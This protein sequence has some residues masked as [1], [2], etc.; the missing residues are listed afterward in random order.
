MTRREVIFLTVL[1]VGIASVWIW[2][3]DSTERSA[4]MAAT[5]A[6]ASAAYYPDDA[7][8]YAWLS[9]TP[10]G[11]QPEYM[12]ELVD[13]FYQFEGIREWVTH[14]ETMLAD[15]TGSNFESIGAWMG[16][17]L[18]AAIFDLGDGQP[19]LAVTVEVADQD[20]A[21]EFLAR[22]IERREEKTSE[23][24]ERFVV[25]DDVI[26]LG[27]GDGW[28]E[29]QVY[30]LAGGVMVFATDWGLLREI[31][32]HV[33]GEQRQTL[34]A[35]TK[36]L[37]A[38]S[39]ARDGRFASVYLDYGRMRELVGDGPGVG[40]CSGVPFTP[41]DW[42]MASA[43]WVDSGLIFDVVAPDVT[44]WWTDTSGEATSEVVPAG[45]LGFVSVGFDPDI[46]RWRDVLDGCELGALLPD[47]GFFGLPGPDDGPMLDGDATVAD[48]L[49]LALGAIE[50]GIG[51]DLEQDLFD[52]LGGEL[53]VAVHPSVGEDSLI[54]GVAALSYHPLSGYE[55]TR[56]LDAL[57][58][59]ISMG[60]AS[61]QVD[62]GAAN[63]GRMVR[64][65][66]S[67]SLGY[68]V[69]GGYLTLG[70]SVEALRATVDVQ[71][72]RGDRL[73]DS[74]K[75]QGTVGHLTYDPRLL[76]YIDIEQIIDHM[77]H[78]EIGMSEGVA[79]VLTEGLSALALGVGTDGDHSRA[80]LIL[81]F[82]PE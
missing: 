29:E 5:R 59:D 28:M 71:T 63:P 25:G 57:A 14:A 33:D 7:V 19:G 16:T 30:A 31:L 34:A 82:L 81:L 3:V 23:P 27:G 53:I 8:A 43:G 11:A 65:G 80:T 77:D 52:H 22:W 45:A 67:F 32:A 50:M 74:G 4:D 58:A 48:A 78:R 18:S 68:V 20:A 60:V 24:F 79:E 56:T 21:G 70:T 47:G 1:A 35:G 39:A 40:V 73:A 64:L 61:E 44:S 54:E 76:A 69:H 15:A 49:D 55:L 37:E 6:E 38:R 12:T 46:D 36:F 26:W 72:G 42:L 10:S 75:Y 62:V 51:L 17:E 13:R 41:P 66:E 9:L 2:R